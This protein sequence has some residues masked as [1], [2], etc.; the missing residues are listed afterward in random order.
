MMP[1]TNDAPT[2]EV[3]MKID[4]RRSTGAGRVFAQG[5][6]YNYGRFLE[7][8]AEGDVGGGKNFFRRLI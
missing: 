8:H 2:R 7:L 3:G 5:G 4:Q 1:N 6:G